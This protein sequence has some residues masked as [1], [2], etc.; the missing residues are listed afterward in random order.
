MVKV[1]E[2]SEDAFILKNI[3]TEEECRSLIRR[4]EEIGYSDAKIISGG[5]QIVAKEM[6][7]NKRVIIDDRYLASEVWT[8]AS[9]YVPEKLDGYNVVGL[10]E[11]FRFLPR[12]VQKLIAT[13]LLD[14]N[15]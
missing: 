14:S 2:I 8:K 12:M 10:N 13:L 9:P 5:K 1:V 3:L 15:T 6:R 7:N 4:T 11:R